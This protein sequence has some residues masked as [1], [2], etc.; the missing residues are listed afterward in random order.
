MNKKEAKYIPTKAMLNVR[1]LAGVYLLFLV[2]QMYQG[3]D[4]TVG[5]EKTFMIAAVVVFLAAG[6]LLIVFSARALKIGRY[7]GGAMFPESKD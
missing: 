4:T 3:L 1:I 6:I 7:I 5:S 2:Y